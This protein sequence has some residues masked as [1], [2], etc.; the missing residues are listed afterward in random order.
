M[1]QAFITIVIVLFLCPLN[2]FCE[3]SEDFNKDY[4]KDYEILSVRYCECTAYYRFVY[5]ALNSSGESK[6]AN[7]Y[8]ELED[9]VMLYALILAQPGRD[10]NKAIEVTSSRI[11]MYSEQ[12]KQGR[13]KNKA[14]EVTSSRIQMYSEQMKQE[15]NNRN[16]NIA[17]LINKY[18]FGCMELIQNPPETLINALEREIKYPTLYFDDERRAG[19][20]QW[21]RIP[22]I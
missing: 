17:I 19:G 3:N 4:N 15:T 7:S 13:D 8:Q 20:R 21:S 2:G 11:Q 6:T 22:T 18:H 12:M 1:K 5:H 9:E 10:K 14:I 16:E